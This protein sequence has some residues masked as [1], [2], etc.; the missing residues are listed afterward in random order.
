MTYTNPGMLLKNQ[1]G[2]VLLISLVLLLGITLLA[3]STL[4]VS[5]IEEKMASHTQ[6]SLLSHQASESAIRE[7]IDD[8]NLL[9]QAIS[10]ASSQVSQPSQITFTNVDN[11]NV[12]IT[13]LGEG[14]S[15]DS[16]S[17]VISG[18]GSFTTFRYELRGSSTIN[19]IDLNAQVIQG[20]YTLGPG[21]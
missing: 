21:S 8:R 14:V 3:T 11:V 9:S 15:A 17:S 2:A 19:N 6:N 18:E 13:Y 1:N 20:V 12:T 5:S 16:A 7:V 4:G 10:S